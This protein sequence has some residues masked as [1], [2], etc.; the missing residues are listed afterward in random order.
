MEL[1]GA[2]IVPPATTRRQAQATDARFVHLVATPMQDSP[3]AF[4]APPVR[5]RFI[6]IKK[7]IPFTLLNVSLSTFMNY[8][9]IM[10][11]FYGPDGYQNYYYYVGVYYTGYGLQCTQCP[12]GTYQANS[13]QVSCTQCN[14]GYYGTVTAGVHSD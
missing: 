2:T 13:G 9:S 1:N 10:T 14:S 4:L 11:G 12:A 3:R 8:V 7:L 5:P 6:G